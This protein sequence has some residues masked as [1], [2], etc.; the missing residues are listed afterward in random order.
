MGQAVTSFSWKQERDP[1]LYTRERTSRHP[2]RDM[3]CSSPETALEL[4]TEESGHCY[5]AYS[6]FH[7]PT[8]PAL[9]LDNAHR[10]ITATTWK[11]KEAKSRS[12]HTSGDQLLQQLSLRQGLPQSPNW[13]KTQTQLWAGEGWRRA[14]QGLSL[15]AWVEGLWEGNKLSELFF[16]FI[17]PPPT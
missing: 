9:F 10:E 12:L 7:Q 2:P 4:H 3:R 6:S 14:L 11:K 16:I 8:G 17:P 13:A 15:P 1:F 5:S